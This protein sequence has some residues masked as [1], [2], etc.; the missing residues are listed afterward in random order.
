MNWIELNR[1]TDESSEREEEEEGEDE[2]AAAAQQQQQDTIVLLKLVAFFRALA[3]PGNLPSAR[4]LCA[5]GAQRASQ[6]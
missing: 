1:E 2:K 3:G 4:S 5:L 6:R